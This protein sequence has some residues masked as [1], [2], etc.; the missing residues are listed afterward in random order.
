MERVHALGKEPYTICK[1][2]QHK[3]NQRRNTIK[4]VLA[5][6]KEPY[7]IC[8]E[9]NTVRTKTLEC[10]LCRNE[11]MRNATP[12]FIHALSSWIVGFFFGFF[13]FYMR[14]ATLRFIRALSS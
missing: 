6:G 9:T 7:T 10:T 11:Y 2:T 8:K 4:R 3:R 12:R 13:F 5:I 14:K 1:E